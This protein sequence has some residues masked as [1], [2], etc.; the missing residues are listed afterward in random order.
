MLTLAAIV[1]FKSLVARLRIPGNYSTGLKKLAASTTMSTEGASPTP[2]ATPSGSIFDDDWKSFGGHDPNEFENLD[3]LDLDDILGPPLKAGGAPDSINPQVLNSATTS[4]RR[5]S[6][7]RAPQDGEE[8][9]IIVGPAPKAEE[10]DQPSAASS[11]Y[12]HPSIEAPY[13]T[14]PTYI[15]VPL[16]SELHRRSVSEPP[17][18]IPSDHLHAYAM[19]T[20]LEPALTFTR[21]GMTIGTPKLHHG[22][23]A[24]RSRHPHLQEPYPT[25]MSVGQDRDHSRPW[26]ARRRRHGPT[27][28]PPMHPMHHIPR[29]QMITQQQLPPS[30]HIPVQRRGPA[31]SSRVCT[32]APSPPQQQQGPVQIDPYLMNAPS[33]AERKAV[34]IPLTVEEL[35]GMITEAVRAALSD[36]GVRNSVEDPSA[37]RGGSEDVKEEQD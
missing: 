12:S 6:N 17:T 3:Y 7:T 8:D 23:R 36:A 31:V 20:M 5:S 9:N 32:P 11:P 16:H 22:N 35:R 4:K 1:I 27:S 2:A 28:V 24:T 14:H 13:P 37:L 29:P 18:G 26:R 10:F 33:V 19:P 25:L 34:T 21:S 30:Q 15:P